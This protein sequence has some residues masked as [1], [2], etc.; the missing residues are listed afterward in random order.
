M[1]INYCLKSN[2]EIEPY[3]ESSSIQILDKTDEIFYSMVD[4]HSKVVIIRLDI[5]YPADFTPSFNEFPKF[6]NSFMV[7]L[8]RKG[9]DPKYLWVCEQVEGNNPHF[10]LCL[11]L[12]GN[13]AKYFH[14]GLLQ[15]ANDYWASSLGV[16]DASGL[17][18]HTGPQNINSC[19]GRDIVLKRNDSRFQELYGEIMRYLS[20][21]AKNATK[22]LKVPHQRR[23]GYSQKL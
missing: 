3:S 18:N 1:I 7:F 21:I 2:E 13:K 23:V 10:H 15:K 14:P 12:N 8:R 5:N 6:I 22:D 19:T 4:R 16:D 17:I 20:Y 11:F 9:F